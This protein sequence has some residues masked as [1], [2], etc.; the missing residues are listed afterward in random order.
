MPAKQTQVSWNSTTQSHS[1]SEQR[2]SR[3]T[4][5]TA[6]IHY[7]RDGEVVVYRRPHSLIWQCRYRL[8][9]Q[10]WVRVST[11]QRN[12]VDATARACELYDEA[13]F[14]RERNGLTPHQRRFSDI[15]AA[16]V[17]ALRAELQAGTGRKITLS[18]MAICCMS[19]LLV[20]DG[21][22]YSGRVFAKSQVRRGAVGKVLW[23]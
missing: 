19:V 9:T 14:F 2:L 21:S 16:T 10:G 20:V 15:A 1:E 5:T 18:L 8:L 22:L 23:L 6:P 11:H 3:L 17:A 12:L 13:R 4:Q 7:R